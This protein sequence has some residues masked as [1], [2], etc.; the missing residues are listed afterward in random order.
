MP[1]LYLLSSLRVHYW[2]FATVFPVTKL[3]WWGFH[4]VKQQ[5][6]SV[7][8]RQTDGQH[9][10]STYWTTDYGNHITSYK[11]VP[12]CSRNVTMTVL[13]RSSVLVASMSP[14]PL[15]LF[16]RN[17]RTISSISA[18]TFL[19]STVRLCHLASCWSCRS[20]VAADNVNCL[21]AMWAL[22]WANRTSATVQEHTSHSSVQFSAAVLHQLH[23]SQLSRKTN[24]LVKH[25]IGQRSAT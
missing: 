5:M 24:A 22:P 6:V 15:R 25:V 12:C 2:N 17:M 20:W 23:N 8:D 21:P 7:T 9:C 14:P 19:T 16:S 4:V 13:L 10:Y 11:L 18:G 3:H 1:H